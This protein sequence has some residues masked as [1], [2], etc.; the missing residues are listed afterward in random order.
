MAK[1]KESPELD[2]AA[3]MHKLLEDCYGEAE[4]I[5]AGD[6]PDNTQSALGEAAHKILVDLTNLDNAARGVALTLIAYKAI[7]PDQDIRAHKSEHE[8]GFS[9]RTIDTKVTVPFLMAKSLPRNVETHWLSQTF[10]FA[11]P[12]V[13]GS[14]LRTAPKAAGSLLIDAVNLVQENGSPEYARAAVVLMLAQRIQIRNRE[15]VVLT[16]PKDLSIEAVA[17]LIARHITQKYNTNAPR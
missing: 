12:Y 10:S 3:L 14:T 6:R 13:R 1:A 17:N 7:F 15:G 9:A 16:R 4:K 8:N 2:K 5:V 11:G